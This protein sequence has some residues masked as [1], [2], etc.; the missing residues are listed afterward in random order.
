[1]TTPKKR[2]VLPLEDR[3][4]VIRKHERDGLSARKIAESLGVGKTQIQNILLE[5]ESILKQWEEG[6]GSDRK[7]CKK[8]KCVYGDINDLVWEWF[9]VARSKNIPITGRMI[10]EKALFYA[11]EADQDEFTGQFNKCVKFHSL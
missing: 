9:T 2:K 6:Q 11:L 1:M 3:V 8:R 7:Y 5:K 10:Q 4:S